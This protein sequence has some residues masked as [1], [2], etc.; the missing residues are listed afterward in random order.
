MF[1]TARRRGRP[2]CCIAPGGAAALLVTPEL[3]RVFLICSRCRES[4]LLDRRW[5][6]QSFGP[7]NG[8]RCVARALACRHMRLA[9]DR[10]IHRSLRSASLVRH[11]D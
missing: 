1:L 3:D 8:V 7:S 6:A 4:Q 9:V 5:M 2:P 11:S 10:S